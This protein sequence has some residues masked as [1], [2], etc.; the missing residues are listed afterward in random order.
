MTVGLNM[1]SADTNHLSLSTKIQY[2]GDWLDFLF[3]LDDDDNGGYTFNGHVKAP[4]KRWTMHI[5]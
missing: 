4:G 2:P 1:F 3:V 5:S